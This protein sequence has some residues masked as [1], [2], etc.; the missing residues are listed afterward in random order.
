[1]DKQNNP[2]PL[3][4]AVALDV[5]FIMDLKKVIRKMPLLKM[6]LQERNLFVLPEVTPG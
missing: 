6:S 1:L 3:V 2:D 4:V 5:A